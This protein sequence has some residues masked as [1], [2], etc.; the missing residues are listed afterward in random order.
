M[1]T[2]YDIVL[3]IPGLPCDGHTLATTSLGGSET[4]GLQLAQA[5]AAQGHAV[6]VFS[7]HGPGQRAGEVA[8]VH[9]RALAGLRDYLTR[10]PHDVFVGQRLPEL[11][12]LRTAGRLSY[13][14][15]HD[16]ALVRQAQAMRG[17]LWNVDG[18]FV[19]SAFMAE[20]YREVYGADL[21]LVVTRNGLDLGLVRQAT[22]SLLEPRRRRRLVW[23]SRPERGLDVLLGRIWPKLAEADPGLELVLC[24][25]ANPVDHLAGLY[26][27]CGRLAAQWPGRVH[28]LG[29]LTKAALYQLYATSGVLV[30]PTPSPVMPTFAEISCLTA[31][32][33]QACGLPIV[34]SAAGALPETVAPGAGVCIEGDPMSDAYV[35][36]FTEAVRRY[37]TD[38]TAWQAASTAGLAAAAGL[39]WSG[40]A[41]QWTETFTARFA[42]VNDSPE[43]LVRHFIRQ[44]DILAAKAVVADMPD[45]EAKAELAA[46]LTERWGFLDTPEGVAAQYAQIGTTHTDVFDVTTH[47]P[48]FQ[49]LEAYLRD[50]PELERILD[51]GCAHGSYCGNLATRVGRT[52]VGVD[53]DPHSIAWA[54][55]N[56][57]TRVPDPSRL[58]FVVGDHTVDL[59]GQAPFDLLIAEEVLEH[60]TDPTAVI[61]ALERWVKPG[62][63]VLLTVPMGPWEYMSYK[64]YPHRAHCWH[65][66]RHDLRDLFGAKATLSISVLP[67]G[68]C[69]ELAEPIGWHVIEYTVQPDRPTGRIDLARKL[70]VQRPM[71]TISALLIAGPKAEQTL[72]WC[73]ASL[74]HVAD[75]VVIGDTGL[76]PLGRAVA[77]EFCR[78]IGVPLRIVPASNPLEHGFETPRNEAL[79]ACRM[80]WVL[81]IDTDE[82]L[83]DAHTLHKYRRRNCFHGY[84][85]K[86]KHVAIDADFPADLPVRMFRRGPNAAG[87]A[88]AW[89]GMIHEHPEFGVNLGPGSTVILHDTAI[90][91][92][93]Y[94]SEAV[95]RRRFA[96]NLPLLEADVAK[97]PDRLLQKHFIIRDSMLLAR[98]ALQ[99]NG[100]RVTPEVRFYCERVKTLYRAHFLG[101]GLYMGADSLQYYSEA[102]GVLGEGEE[103]AW[104]V[105]VAKDA[106][107]TNGT[108]RAR[109]ANAE[110]FLTELSVRT[111][112]QAAPLESRYY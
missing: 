76:S 94:E 29:A 95:R 60:V 64:T 57:D 45:G 10:V 107:Q 68:D 33:A 15:A 80:D 18:V 86:Q 82:R 54:E 23:A 35:E 67:F 36:A 109:F 46:D 70:R 11:F 62:G 43:R 42:E 31:M 102:L 51:Y 26:A 105:A 104:Q 9:Y 97:Y 78:L 59:S 4:A 40:V 34:T 106:A 66:D 81:W 72:G 3:A 63:T 28:G 5:L 77:E 53:I 110:E 65:Y 30:Y 20:Q 8:G 32:E 47:E 16:L 44:S 39:D 96:R 49:H 58:T 27:E 87:Q 73:L 101:K 37:V 108:S 1:S 103:F 84:S 56:R 100:G 2:R 88:C 71:E 6:T 13:L 12:H 85:I 24:G 14:W 7:N 99:Q 74:E 22:E 38:D 21:P 93:G 91:H 75:E 92:V 90:L 17:V 55:R 41:S 61:D 111:R 112:E 98:Y 52:W 19:L 25:Y 50:H 89:V 69:E 83:V 79:A 48:R